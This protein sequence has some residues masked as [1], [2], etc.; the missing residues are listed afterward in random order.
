MLGRQHDGVELDRLVPVVGDGDLGLAVGT[1]V[2]DLAGLAHSR[3][4]L[5]ETM[6]EV[7][8]QR[9][10][11]GGV[12]AGVAEH[13]ALVAGALL[14]HRVH[15]AGAALIGRVDALGDIGRLLADRDRDTARLTV[16]ALGRRVVADP[17]D[18]VSHDPWDVHVT[19]RGHLPG[20]VYQ[21]GGDHGLHCDA[22]GLILGEHRI[23]DRIADLITDLVGVALSD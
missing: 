12:L 17:Q 5:S 7:D 2:G 10:Q 4:A 18:R 1:Q 6:G 9:H 19:R 11:L 15:A 21:A 20:D 14:I 23:Q 22:A 3:K 13:Q 8:R 16:E